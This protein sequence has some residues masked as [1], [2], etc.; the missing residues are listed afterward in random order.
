MALEKYCPICRARY[1]ADTTACPT[2]GMRLFTRTDPLVGRLI[3][4][5]YR[6]VRKLSAGKMG[7][8]Y[9]VVEAIGGRLFA[10]KVISAQHAGDRSKRARLI[11]ESRAA[12]Q[13]AHEHIIRVTDFD[14]THDGL[15]YMVME[16]LAGPTL[17]RVISREPLPLHRAVP[18]G[19]QIARGLGRAHDLG[20]VHR[21][22][23]PDNILFASTRGQPDWVKLADFGLASLKGD[24]RL[25]ASGEI[26]G[27]PEYFSP[28]QAAGQKATS[29]SDLYSLGAVFYE[30]VTGVLPFRGDT[31]QIMQ[32]HMEKEPL[33][34][35]RVAAASHIPPELDRLI[36]ALMRKDPKDRYLD[37]HHLLEDLDRL[38]GQL[39]AG[40]GSPPQPVGP[41]AVGDEQHQ[42]DPPTV[43]TVQTR[44][45]RVEAMDR[46]RADVPNG[47]HP[48][49]LAGC[50]ET[51]GPLLDEASTLEQ[52]LLVKVE[53]MKRAER[54]LAESREKLGR[55]VDKAAAWASK[56]R[57]HMDA[58][59]E[60]AMTLDNLSFQIEQL[61]GRM[62]ALTA[63][64]DHDAAK[65]KMAYSSQAATLEELLGR[66]DRIA[67]RVER[68]L[69]SV[70]GAR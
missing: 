37:A 65:T 15:V 14:E 1:P 60:P 56:L 58:D 59:L 26:F 48:S 32:Q 16:H 46:A 64:F 62:A 7:A 52:M 19:I 6:V 34:P 4:G 47:V 43:Q 38:E 31:T 66:T 25:T 36:L 12:R 41:V 8:V 35:S 3:N 49:W 23:K 42:A 10:M 9:Q 51:L 70:P 67:E 28:E 45:D 44:R 55:S 68:F 63:S 53:S 69:R 33:A 57:R 20:V 11:R 40:S 2:D 24:F 5:R 29:A 61:R 22:I 27:T 21:D 30:M 50:F 13:V 17:A 18:I 39:P 54:E